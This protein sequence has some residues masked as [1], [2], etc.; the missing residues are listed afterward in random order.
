[1][2]EHCETNYTW[3]MVTDEV[4]SVRQCNSESKFVIPAY[5]F[6]KF[7]FLLF[8]QEKLQRRAGKSLLHKQEHS[9]SEYVNFCQKSIMLIMN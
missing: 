3:D 2:W 4:P 7:D 6:I 8:S 1:M 5:L 9:R